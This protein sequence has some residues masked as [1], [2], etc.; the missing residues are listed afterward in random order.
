MRKM[1]KIK[2][3]IFMAM[4]TIA[5]PSFA[6]NLILYDFN[7]QEGQRIAGSAYADQELAR[8]TRQGLLRPQVVPIDDNG[9]ELSK[10]ID[11]IRPFNVPP[12]G[13][14]TKILTASVRWIVTTQRDGPE[15]F[16]QAIIETNQSFTNGITM[17]TDQK[18][19]RSVV[20]GVAK[21]NNGGKP[22]FAQR[23]DSPG[24][25]RMLIGLVVP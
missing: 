4:L 8:L 6:S 21:M 11:V 25:P 12:L 13:L 19:F 17:P 15:F 1:K 3:T 20:A 23:Y 5:S 16:Y 2:L 22:V 7:A 18:S 14:G 9:N 10:T 24:G